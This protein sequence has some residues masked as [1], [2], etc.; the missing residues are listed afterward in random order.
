LLPVTEDRER[1]VRTK[2]KDAREKEKE[3][4]RKRESERGHY[5]SLVNPTRISQFMAWILMIQPTVPHEKLCF[6]NANEISGRYDSLMQRLL[7]GVKISF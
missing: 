6:P 4:E 7:H 3:R 1:R 2:E 5:L